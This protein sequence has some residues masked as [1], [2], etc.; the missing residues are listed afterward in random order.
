MGLV[1]NDCMF[2]GGVG[3]VGRGWMLVDGAAAAKG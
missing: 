3:S 2:V 1:V